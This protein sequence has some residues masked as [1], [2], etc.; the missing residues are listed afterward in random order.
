MNIL[1][2]LMFLYFAWSHLKD[3][4]DPNR[5][6]RSQVRTQSFTLI[7]LSLFLTYLLLFGGAAGG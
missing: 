3:F 4:M 5:M 6:S 2:G 7:I 1:L